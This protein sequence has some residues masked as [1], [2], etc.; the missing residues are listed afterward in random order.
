[1]FAPATAPSPACMDPFLGPRLSEDG[2]EPVSR[3]AR[4]QPLAQVIRALGDIL[5]SENISMMAKFTSAKI[6]HV[7]NAKGSRGIRRGHVKPFSMRNEAF[8][9]LEALRSDPTGEM[10]ANG[11]T[12]LID[13]LDWY[14]GQSGPYASVNFARDH[15]HAILVGPG[16]VEERLDVR[17]GLTL[18]APYTRF[19]DH[20]QTSNRVVVALSEGEFQSDGG[21]WFREKAG[22]AIFYPTGRRFAMR[23]TAAPLMTLWCQRLNA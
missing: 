7:L 10:L 22:S 1:M 17:V 11:L 4:P 19:P 14:R 3:R 13:E 23:C 2:T 15:A 16:G 18:M 8:A 20:Q 6:I 9:A 12:S 21:D 5:L